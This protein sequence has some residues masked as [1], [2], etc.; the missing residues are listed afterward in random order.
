[1][2]QI[3]GHCR[4]SQAS[5]VIPHVLAAFIYPPWLLEEREGEKE[6]IYALFLTRSPERGTLCHLGG[7]TDESVKKKNTREEAVQ[8]NKQEKTGYGEGNGW[9]EKWGENSRRIVEVVGVGSTAPDEKTGESRWDLRRRGQTWVP[10]LYL[11]FG[12]SVL[13]WISMWADCLWSKPNLMCEW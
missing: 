12:S 11:F 2:Q 10:L 4:D 9:G 7:I 8:W 5:A 13:C 3:R 1:M 6:T